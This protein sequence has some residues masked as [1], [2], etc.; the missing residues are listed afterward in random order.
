MV[1]VT[2]F[3]FFFIFLL[4]ILFT[5]SISL[6]FNRSKIFIV[7]TFSVVLISLV[8]IFSSCFS[9]YMHGVIAD[10]LGLVGDSISTYIFISVMI[11][12]L[13]NPIIS[14]AKK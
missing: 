3:R 14:I 1:E 8:S 4:L 6:F 9:I 13:L 11:L 12:S 2:L 10:E 7:N 5:V